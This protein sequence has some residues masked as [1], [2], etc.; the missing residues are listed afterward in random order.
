MQAILLAEQGAV[1]REEGSPLPR[2]RDDADLARDPQ[3][4]DGPSDEQRGTS[5][6]TMSTSPLPREITV[7]RWE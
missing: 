3:F 1:G 4:P 2:D 7:S 5:V 6:S